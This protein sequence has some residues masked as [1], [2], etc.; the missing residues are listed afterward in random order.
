MTGH[1]IAVDGDIH[2]VGV[3]YV[4]ALLF[5]SGAVEGADHAH[6]GQP[7]IDNQ[8]EPV[9]LLLHHLEERNGARHDEQNRDDQNWHRHDE[10][11]R[12]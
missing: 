12:Q 1:M 8:V 9:E 10:D 6:A 3:G 4:E 5:R 2:D 11:P 7:L